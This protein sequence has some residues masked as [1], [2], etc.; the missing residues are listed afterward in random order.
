MPTIVHS[1]DWPDRVVVGT[2]GQPG[3]RSFYLQ[4]RT[5]PRVVSVSL[6]KE[7]SAVLAETIEEILDELMADDGNPFHVPADAPVELIDND[8]LDQPV[9]PEFRTGSISLGWDP[10]TAQ[11]VIEAYP[12]DDESDEDGDGDAEPTETFVIRIPVGLA[13]AFA[14]RTLEIVAAGRPPKSDDSL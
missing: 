14:A 10:S 1:F 8:P 13:R 7:Q 2:I 11:L 3:S 5:G 12:I 4:A 9:E 6:E